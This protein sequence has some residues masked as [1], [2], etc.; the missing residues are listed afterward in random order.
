MELVLE[1]F[2]VKQPVLRLSAKYSIEEISLLHGSLRLYFL[3][4][5]EY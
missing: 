5:K 1:E 2:V 4:I 3:R